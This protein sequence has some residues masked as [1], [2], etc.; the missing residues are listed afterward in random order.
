[1]KAKWCFTVNNEPLQFYHNLEMLFRTTKN[2]RYI[3]GQLER[4]EETGKLHFQGYLQLKRS[5]RLSWLKNN[6]HPTAHYEIQRGTNAEARNYTFKDATKELDWI[7]FG[8]FVVGAGTRT[9]LI[10]YR[11]AIINGAT[12]R[13]LIETHP[14]ELAKYDRFYHTVRSIFMP[15]RGEVTVELYFG[16]PGSGKTRKAFEEN[17]DLYVMPLTSTSLWFDGYDGHKTVLLDDFCGASSKV[18]LDY[19]L[20]LLDRYPVQLPIKGG[21]VWWTAEKII[22]TTNIHPWNWYT[23]DGRDKQW[24]ALKRRI[25]RVLVFSMNNEEPEEIED[26]DK[27]FFE[28]WDLIKT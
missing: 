12:K 18:S 22:L 8:E 7:E 24:Q 20:R 9:D 1:M 3:C 10:S 15:H 21:H 17:E 19:T 27:D 13:E 2:I 14:T 25:H 28:D 4:G 11:D 16:D 5:Q 6:L 26:L 23:W